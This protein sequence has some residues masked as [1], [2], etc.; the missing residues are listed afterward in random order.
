MNFFSLSETEKKSC[1]FVQLRKTETDRGREIFQW[2]WLLLSVIRRLNQLKSLKDYYCNERRRKKFTWRLICSK[3]P[4]E[5]IELIKQIRRRICAYLYV[6][7][8]AHIMRTMTYEIHDIIFCSVS[9]RKNW[10]HIHFILFARIASNLSAWEREQSYFLLIFNRNMFM[11]DD[12]GDV[13]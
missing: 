1:I 9:T 6:Y 11:W 2:M 12:M 13:V 5:W 10:I 3:I 8:S 7:D 4:I